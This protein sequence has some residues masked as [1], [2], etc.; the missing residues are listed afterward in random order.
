MEV[1]QGGSLLTK[2]L[3]FL[4]PSSFFGSQLPSSEFIGS[5]YQ[6]VESTVIVLTLVF[7]T[8]KEAA[9][10]SINN[11]ACCKLNPGRRSDGTEIMSFN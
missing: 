11:S 6:M 10:R 3:F 2:P 4:L 8:R 9:V 1:E 7:L 5:W